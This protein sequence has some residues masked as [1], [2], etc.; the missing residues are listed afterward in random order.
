MPTPMVCTKWIGRYAAQV[1]A[2]ALHVIF[3]HV[4]TCVTHT[5]TCAH[6]PTHKHIL[7]RAHV[8]AHMQAN[9][10]THVNVSK[11]CIITALRLSMLVSFGLC[12]CMQFRPIMVY[13]FGA[14]DLDRLKAVTTDERITLFHIQVCSDVAPALR[15][16][17]LHLCGAAS[18][19]L[20]WH[21]IA[22]TPAA[23]PST[24]VGLPLCGTGALASCVMCRA[25]I[26]CGVLHACP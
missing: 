25:T 23:L 3:P 1:S 22:H 24:C 12:C 5:D 21:G 14:V 7:A 2:Y 4:F 15:H 20:L 26:A 9:A 16:A 18:A 17:L 11:L 10:S 8:H 19:L 6:P 13:K